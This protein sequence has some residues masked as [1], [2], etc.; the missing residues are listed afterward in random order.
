M[1]THKSSCLKTWRR[2]AHTDNLLSTKH[3]KKKNTFKLLCSIV[4]FSQSAVSNLGVDVDT[5]DL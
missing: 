1:H 4:S 5:F 3:E 2:T